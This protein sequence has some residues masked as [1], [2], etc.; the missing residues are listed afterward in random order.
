MNITHY[1]RHNL[2]HILCVNLHCTVDN[3]DDDDDLEF[4]LR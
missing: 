2:L 3:D 4:G 1:I